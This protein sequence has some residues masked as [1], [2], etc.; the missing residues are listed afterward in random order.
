VRV[1]ICGGGPAGLY[2]ALL[3]KKRH[4]GAEIVVHEQNAPDSTYGWGVVFSGRAQT[5]LRDADPESYEDIA[6]TMVAWDELTVAHHDARMR[7]DNS[8][9]SGVSRIALLTVLQAHCRRRGVEL[10]FHS[11]IADRAELEDADLVVAADG[12]RSAIRRALESSF[13][14]NASTLTNKY[15]WYGTR[16]LFDTLTLTFRS[17]ADGYFVAHSYP[18]GPDYSTFLVECDAATWNKAGL[19]RRSDDDARRYCAE[20]FAND[21]DGHELLS[22]K[23]KWLNFNVVTNA[24]WVAGN[25]VLIGDA[26]RTVH[27]SIGSGTR[28][29]LED[30]IALANALAPG[31]SVAEAL[32]AY[33][34]ERRPSSKRLLD[35]AERSFLWYEDFGRHMALPAW[36]FAHSYMTRGGLVDEARLRERSPRFMASCESARARSSPSS[37]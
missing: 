7:V 3:Y 21:L 9:F 26:A 33:E 32:L 13:R 24:R 29:G 19:D 25:V 37:S 1:T 15:I 5:F 20:V 2:F 35:V 31:A 18:Y 12:A 30:A 23:S 36:E 10:R 27:F 34:A 11:T 17:N 28:S 22:N 6:K 4:P 16:Q 8:P 14:P